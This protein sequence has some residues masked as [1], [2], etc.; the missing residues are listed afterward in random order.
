MGAG[1]GLLIRNRMAFEALKDVDVVVF[2]KTGTLTRDE[3]KAAEVLPA[4]G[5]SEEEVL[6]LAVSVERGSEHTLA[7]GIVKEAERRGLTLLRVERF[8]VLPGLGVEGLA[9]GRKVLVRRLELMR[10]WG[11]EVPRNLKT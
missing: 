5:V 2:D 7:R 10:E 8:R 4:P 6:T 11:V 9:N 3:F 1:N